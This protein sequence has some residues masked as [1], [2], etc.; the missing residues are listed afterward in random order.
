MRVGRIQ[1]GLAQA[2]VDLHDVHVP[3]T[4]GQ[5]LGQ[6]AQATADLQY[7][8]L[9]GQLAPR[10]D[11][12]EDVR[13]DQEVLPQFTIRAHVEALHAPQGRLGRALGRPAAHHQPNTRAALRSTSASSSLLTPRSPA[14]NAAVCATNA[15]WLR[16]LRTTC[17]VR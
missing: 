8:V 7:D 11:H 4:L 15:G 9:L 14:T 2:L 3:H 6:H 16:C 17:G 12:P 13:V 1:Q 5:V 10:V